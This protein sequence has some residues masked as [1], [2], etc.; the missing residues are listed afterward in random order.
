MKKAVLFI[1]IFILG[2]S[3]CAQQ[4]TL[5]GGGIQSGGFGGPVVKFTSITDEFAVFV[6]GRGGWI[7]NKTVTLGGGGY[8]LTNTIYFGNGDD[9]RIQMGYGGFEAGLNLA[10]DEL[11]HTVFTVLIGSGAVS[12][13]QLDE[14]SSKWESVED[15]GNV[16]FVLEPSAGVTLNVLKNFRIEAGG[17][18]R[19]ISGV[20]EYGLTNKNLSGLSAHIT[21]KF[22]SFD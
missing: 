6:G 2:S 3:V 8:G 21:F 17:S 1:G 5:F 16:F 19:Y 4:K 20:K 14:E 11:I 7:I 18:Y 13:L 9:K 15:N 10:S 12:I 22:G